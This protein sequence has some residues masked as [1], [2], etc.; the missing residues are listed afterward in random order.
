VTLSKNPANSKAG[1]VLSQTVFQT[2]RL[3]LGR[4]LKITYVI[5]TQTAWLEQ[6][7]VLQTARLEQ[8]KL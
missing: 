5:I 3:E 1:A 6:L 4:S 2:A 8:E 7:S